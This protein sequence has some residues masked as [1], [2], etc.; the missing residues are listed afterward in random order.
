M[1]MKNL[2]PTPMNS[3]I[4]FVSNSPAADHRPCFLF[5]SSKTQE[6]CFPAFVGIAGGTCG[7]VENAGWD[8][9]KRC[10]SPPECL[11][12]GHCRHLVI[13]DSPVAPA[14]PPLH[15][16]PGD[17]LP[18]TPNLPLV[19]GTCRGAHADFAGE[20]EKAAQQTRS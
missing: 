6:R 11:D 1:N 19:P 12:T 7:R 5:F 10:A 4:S 2:L 13:W 15:G 18:G 8:Q 9:G 14:E 16:A 17:A 3:C 20:D